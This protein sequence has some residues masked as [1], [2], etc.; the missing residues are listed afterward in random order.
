MSLVNQ[1]H[2]EFEANQEL[3]LIA[4][5]QGTAHLDFNLSGDI[6]RQALRRHHAANGKGFARMTAIVYRFFFG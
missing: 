6:A 2:S 1:L 3:R 5:K 4:K